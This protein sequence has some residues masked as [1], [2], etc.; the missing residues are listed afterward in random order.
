MI[1]TASLMILLAGSA[2]FAAD[3]TDYSWANPTPDELLRPM[4]TDRPDATESPTTV[5][6]GR[7]QIEMSFAQHTRDHRHPD[8]SDLRIS[9]WNVAPVN[10]RVGLTHDTE[11]QIV[12]D[13]YLRIEERSASA[14]TRSRASGWGDVTLRLKRNFLG[15]EGGETAVGLMPFIKIPT[16]SGG[17]GNN[18]VEGGLI[19]PA[20]VTVGGREFG[21]MTVLEIIHDGGGYT[22]AWLNT[23]AT[24]A[25]FTETLA[26]FIELASVTGEGSHS[27]TFN[28]GLTLAV[29]GDLQLDAGVNV[30]LTR[31]APDLATFIGISVRY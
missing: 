23:I 17:V 8:H 26:G 29:S 19:V 4:V 15:N 27:L 25:G 11:L 13:N 12:V 6:A 28:A 21:V 20:S 14:A 1:R 7:V 31:A 9:E 24:G 10:V 2:A 22:A 30:G 18:R 3:K 5:D 16:N